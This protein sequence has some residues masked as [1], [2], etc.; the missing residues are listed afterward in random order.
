M[1]QQ[2]IRWQQRFSNYKMALLQLQ[3]AVDLSKQRELTDLEKQG[4]IQAFEFTHE[5]AWNMFKDYLEDQGNQNV[6]GSKD[7][8]REAFKV[9]LITDGEQWMSMIQSRNISSHTYNRHTAEELVDVIVD[10]YFPLFETLKTE[11]EKYFP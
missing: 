4:V 3:S 5:L 7:A 9:A 10:Q 11:M 1:T 8:T 6:K 2:D